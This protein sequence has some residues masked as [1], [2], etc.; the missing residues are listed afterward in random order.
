MRKELTIIQLLN[1]T[2]DVIGQQYIEFPRALCTT[3]GLPVKGQKSIATN[4]YQA[5]YKDS[6]LII[7]AFPSTWIADAVILEGMFLINTKPLHS[8]KVMGNYG[9]F[10]MRRFIVP[11]LKKGSQ[12]VHLL[13]DDPGRQSENP[14]Q[15]EQS[16]RDTSLSEHICFVFFDDA[17]VP[18]KWQPTIKCRTCKRR[19]TTFLS[20]YFVQNI[21]PFL[22]EAQKYVTSQVYWSQRGQEHVHGPPSNQV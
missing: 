7:H 2:L 1:Q 21:R 19:L 10:L 12:E 9:N 11:Y 18:A 17:E 13:F 5:R 6:D 3:D 16:R 15:F 14:K 22:T 8:H 20:G 4:F